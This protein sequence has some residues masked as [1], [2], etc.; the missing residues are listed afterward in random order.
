VVPRQKN[1]LMRVV[2]SFMQALFF[3]QYI[4]YNLSTAERQLLSLK[5]SD[6]SPKPERAAS[7]GSLIECVSFIRRNHSTD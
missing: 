2:I 3:Y 1:A 4:K 5:E 7:N 6:T